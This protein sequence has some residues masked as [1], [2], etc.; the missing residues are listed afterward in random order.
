MSG[1]WEGTFRDAD[2]RAWFTV[3]NVDSD[4]PSTG[5]MLMADQ[6]RPEIW[7]HATLGIVVEGSGA[8]R[9]EVEF[10]DYPLRFPGDEKEHAET[11]GILPG[12]MLGEII[13]DAFRTTL[14]SNGPARTNGVI[15]ALRIDRQV[16]DV[17]TPGDL[18]SWQDFRSWIQ[19]LPSGS[20]SP[21]IFRGQRNSAWRLA[22]HF[23][24]HP[25]GRRDV[26]RFAQEDLPHLQSAIGK[27]TG[28]GYR[29]N[30]REEYESLLSIAQHHGYPTPLLDWTESPHVAAYFAL[31]HREAAKT[32]HWRI[33]A[34]NA[35]KFLEYAMSEWGALE[36]P[37]LYLY[38][39]RASRR[40]NLRAKAQQSVFMLSNVADI[41]GFV[42]RYERI[43]LP[44]LLKFDLPAD[45][46][47]QAREDLRELSI[48][49]SSL[50]PSDSNCPGCAE[51][52]AA[53]KQ[54]FFTA[55]Q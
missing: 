3:V 5:R 52:C 55:V 54:R 22:S 11:A 53:L 18:L 19:G 43:G 49:E 7:Q 29:F 34:F 48:T 30:V 44:L 4:R 41:E 1:Q 33:Y 24:R 40:D 17:S 13:P 20:N 31:P 26:I 8:L 14:A 16:E 36:V 27:A 6:E 51:V 23:H 15:E 25:A 2:G 9:A 37:L 32:E 50:F 45:D 28:R 35:T 10:S 38:T 46:A 47:P 12:R 39:V 21:W 42:V